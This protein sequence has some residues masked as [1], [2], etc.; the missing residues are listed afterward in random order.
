MKKML[1]LAMLVCMVGLMTGFSGCASMGLTSDV[2]KIEASC[3]SGT[4]ALQ[5][6]AAANRAGK[7]TAAQNAVVARAL[8]AFTEVCTADTPPTLDSLKGRAMQEAVAQFST[9]VSRL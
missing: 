6:I 3:A 1:S 2:Q 5:G 9:I 8:P 4:A 7:V